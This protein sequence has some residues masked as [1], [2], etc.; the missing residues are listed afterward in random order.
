MRLS[1]E[2]VAIIRRKV[3]KSKINIESL[4]DDVLDHLCCVV[5]IK[6]DRGKDFDVAVRE[7]LHELAPDGLDE[8]Q[9]ETIFLLNSTKIILM[10]KLMY[11]IGLLSAIGLSLGWTF[12]ILHWPGGDELIIYGALG[13]SLLFLPMIT[14]NYF[15]LNIN[16]AITERLRFIVGILSAL[17]ISLAFTF[18]F[19]HL[20]GA[21][22]L[23]IAGTLIFSF[24]YLPFLFFS[25]YKKSVS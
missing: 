3:D 7:A 4:R 23:L 14:V 6:M 24:G 17:V 25:M 19:M 22:M 21:D 2:Q 8:I 16:S 20:Q 15:K 12:K 13:F 5:D 9:R 11:L 1:S 18:K 10:K